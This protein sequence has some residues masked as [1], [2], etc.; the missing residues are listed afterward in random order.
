MAIKFEKI[1]AGA[2]LYDRHKT[3]AG[4][5]NMRVLGEWKVFV[6]SVN[7]R[8]RSAIV[9]WNGNRDQTWSARQLEK[10]S[11]WSMYDADVE[12]KQGMVGTISCRKIRK[13]GA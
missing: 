7:A 9:S 8:D 12:R 13:A 6:R 3:L 11:T 5:T 4:N 10:L 1:Q 2:T